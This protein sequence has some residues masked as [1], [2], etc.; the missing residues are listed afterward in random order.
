[1]TFLEKLNEKS[2]F[3][4]DELQHRSRALSRYQRTFIAF[5]D[6]MSATRQLS[7][8]GLIP[9]QTH[10]S[11]NFRENAQGCNP[12]CHPQKHIWRNDSHASLTLGPWWVVRFWFIT[13]ICFL[14]KTLRKTRTNSIFHEEK[15]TL[16]LKC[17][18]PSSKK[19]CCH[20]QRRGLN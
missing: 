8:T 2:S 20:S 5:P 14:K 3:I 9:A 11:K 10:G 18:R 15:N 16:F 19:L 12:S 6:R 7:K 17:A 1:M 13:Y 4:H